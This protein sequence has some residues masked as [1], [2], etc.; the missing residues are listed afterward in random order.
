MTWRIIVGTLSLVITMILLGYVAVT[1]QER[2]SVFAAAYDS[3]QVETG[4]ALYEG[5]CATC[6]GLNGE[7]TGRAPTLN[8]PDLLT[9]NSPR[10]QEVGWTGTVADYVELTIAAGRPRPSDLGQQYAER[11]PTWSQE[12]GGPL[13]TDQVQ[14][15]TSFIMNWA[16][17]F[18]GQA[19]GPAAPQVEGVGTDISVEL[20]EGDP[21][22]G[23]VLV[24]NPPNGQGC[25]VCHVLGAGVTTT[26]GPNWEPTAENNNQGIGTRAAA[27]IT[28]PDYT[29][30]AETPGQYLFESIVQPDVHV[31]AGYNPVMPKTYGNT[32]DAQMMADIIAY[33]LTIE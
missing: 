26:V 16:A 25:T 5:N 20:P 13:R 7:G 2:M 31:V 29:G 30:S 27:R 21:A 18:D 22:N 33:L 6:H 8:T 3:R 12:Y 1:E 14:A 15:L 24:G 32:I 17:A 4:A 28:E 23:E 10:L 19:G 11:M 9:E